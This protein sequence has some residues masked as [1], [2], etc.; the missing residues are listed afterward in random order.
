MVLWTT[1]RTA[2]DPADTTAVSDPFP[3]S[4]HDF[5]K[6]YHKTNL[7][8]TCFAGASLHVKAATHPNHGHGA[9]AQAL[10]WD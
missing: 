8:L 6:S 2:A 9:G 3:T 4:S 1:Q 7:P 5:Y 10:L